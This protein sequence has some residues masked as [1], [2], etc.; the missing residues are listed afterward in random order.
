[1]EEPKTP[2][3]DDLTKVVDFLNHQLR[4]QQEWSIN[5]EY[6]LAFSANNLNNIRFI[7]VNGEIV[8]HAV[9]KVLL[10]KSPAGLF[11]V[12]A[13]G[14]VVT[15]PQYRQKGYST[16]VVQSCLELAR[17]EDCDLAILWTDLFDFYR[18]IGFE[19]A[20]QEISVVLE[21][22]LK[23]PAD[24]LRFVESPRVD[25]QAIA[26]LY[27]RHTVGSIRSAQDIQKFLAIPNSRVF[28]AWDSTNQLQAYAIM[29]R[30]ADL[31]GYIHEWGG[32]VSKLLPLFSHIRQQ[33]GQG[34]TVILPAHAQN[35]I[36]HL[37]QQPVVHAEGY[38]GMMKMINDRHLLFKTQRYA[39]SLGIHNL[40]F[41]KLD[42]GYRLGVD[43]KVYKIANPGDL[44]QVLF[45]PRR[46]AEFTNVDAEVQ[47]VLERV[48]PLPLWVWGWDSV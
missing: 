37:R 29:G 48:L 9:V 2:T 27:S 46:V 30:G 28:T 44:L 17:Q 32:G 18:R 19:L 14:S 26:R 5:A 42:E 8:S 39:R 47:Q 31:T 25:P 16:K 22:E 15:H 41:D 11:K 3:A 24:G 20:G 21:Q 1:M 34:I 45:G 7:E 36:S 10:I 12:A 13:I 4:P 33:F 40:V 38:L 43:N 35:L 23:I 6:P